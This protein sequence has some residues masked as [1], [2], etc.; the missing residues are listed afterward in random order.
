MFEPYFSTK[1]LMDSLKSALDC[2]KESS[3]FF[4]TKVVSLYIPIPSP[5]P[6]PIPLLF[7]F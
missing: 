5:I 6:F 4:A 2:S 1:G 3:A 7:C